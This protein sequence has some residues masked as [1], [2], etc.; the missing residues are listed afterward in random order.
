MAQR[1]QAELSEAQKNDVW[2]RWK[3]GKSSN[4]IGRA[5]WKPLT[6]ILCFLS[7][8]GELFR[9]PTGARC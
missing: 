7:H 3:A 4:M 9:Q 8:H 5:C 1:K 6:S 2:C